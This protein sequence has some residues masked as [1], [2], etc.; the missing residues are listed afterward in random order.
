M[1]A[2]PIQNCC[3]LCNLIAVG[4]RQITWAPGSPYPVE[5]AFPGST[6]K[7]SIGPGGAGT[8]IRL[9]DTPKSEWRMLENAWALLASNGEERIHGKPAARTKYTSHL[10]LTELRE[11][12][13]AQ[14]KPTTCGTRLYRSASTTGSDSTYQHINS[15]MDRCKELHPRCKKLRSQASGDELWLPTRLLDIRSRS[16]DGQDSV[17]LV[18]GSGRPSNAEY[19]TLS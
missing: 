15:W 9:D 18:E 14:L 1:I 2:D 17:R 19:A 4:W 12:Q 11:D 5:R 16:D 6:L 3:R 13:G 8:D 7:I 10:K